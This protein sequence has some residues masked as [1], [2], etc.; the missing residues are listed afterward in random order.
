MMPSLSWTACL[1]AP[2]LFARVSAFP[3][4]GGR[5]LGDLNAPCPGLA[6]ENV[7]KSSS[8]DAPRVRAAEADYDNDP[9]LQRQTRFNTTVPTL[10]RALSL[11]HEIRHDVDKLD[12]TQMCVAVRT[13]QMCT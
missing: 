7:S 13:R 10:A 11:Y 6:R 9:A 5:A 8:A 2:A 12:P 4:M 1:L 3:T